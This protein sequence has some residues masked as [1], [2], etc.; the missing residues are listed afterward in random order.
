MAA[1]PPLEWPR[2]TILRHQHQHHRFDVPPFGPGAEIEASR[3]CPYHCSFCA[4]EKFRDRYRKRPLS[5]ILAELDGLIAH[6]IEYVYFIDEI[7]LPSAELLDALT[8]RDVVFGVQTRIDLWSP[9]M[10]DCL[11]QAGCVSVEAG[12]ES[13]SPEGREL[14]DKQCKLSTEDLTERLVYAKKSIPFVQANLL[15]AKVD[16]PPAIE[17]WRHQLQRYGVWANAPVPLFPY[18]GSP[19]YTGLWGAP[20]DLAWERAHAHYL[21][22]HAGFSDIQEAQPLP[23][24]QLEWPPAEAR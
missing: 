7:F 5:T 15:D 24:H 20:D 6:G 11:G 1:L 17:A 10:L 4:K 3:G 21:R 2:E 14:L 9:A 23:L 13:I 19:A 16:D 12:V 18:P 8:A 22:E